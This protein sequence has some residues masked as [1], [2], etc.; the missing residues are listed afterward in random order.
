[1][2]NPYSAGEKR[3]G[4]GRDFPT[5]GRVDPLGYRERDARTQAR[6]N[7]VLRRMQKALTGQYMDPDVRRWQ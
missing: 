6:K 4:A 1:V 3:Y 5:M 2:F 7:A